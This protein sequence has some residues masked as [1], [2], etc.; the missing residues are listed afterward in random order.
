MGLP[1][2]LLELFSIAVLLINVYSNRLHITDPPVGPEDY[3]ELYSSKW[4]MLPVQ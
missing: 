2:S 4:F 3:P 1:L